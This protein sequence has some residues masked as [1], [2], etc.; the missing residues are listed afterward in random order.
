[1]RGRLLGALHGLRGGRGLDRG[2]GVRGGLGGLRSDR[3]LGSGRFGG[4]G[5]FL[6]DR[7]R[8]GGHGFRRGRLLTG[9]SLVRGLRGN[10][11]RVL[12]CRYGGVGGIGGRGLRYLCLLGLYGVVDGGGLGR[13]CV[14]RLHG[15][16]H[17]GRLGRLG[18]LRLDGLLHRRRLLRRRSGLG[19][20]RLHD[21]GLLRHLGG[22]LMRT[23]RL[24]SGHLRHVTVDDSG[25]SGVALRCLRLLGHDHRRVGV[26]RLLRHGL[27]SNRLLGGGL[28]RR[29]SFLRRLS[30]LD[31]R[32]GHATVPCRTGVRNDGALGRRDRGR[33]HRHLRTL[34]LRRGHAAVPGHT[35][36][37]HDRCALL[38]VRRHGRLLALGGDRRADRL[39]GGPGDGRPGRVR[40][41]RALGDPGCGLPGLGAAASRARGTS[42]YSGPRV[43]GPG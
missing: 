1:M 42:R 2:H 7:L 8:R 32:H 23:D 25:L 43:G 10:G 34:G 13:L 19:R 26:L 15:V 12:G 5:G 9:R 20:A 33:V 14:L 27:V 18:R 17:G 24:V 38:A 35:L 36:L 21:G 29:H 39:G 11:L 37:R 28:L 16:R 41:A 6:G 31:L 3:R 40:D 4:R 22:G 30:T